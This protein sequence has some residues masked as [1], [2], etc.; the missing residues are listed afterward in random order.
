MKF[1]IVFCVLFIFWF[2]SQTYWYNQCENYENKLNELKEKHEELE[3]EYN[4]IE[5]NV[6]DNYSSWNITNSQFRAIV[7]REQE[8]IIDEMKDLE[9]EYEKAYSDYSDCIQEYEWTYTNYLNKSLEYYEKWDY[10]NA[11]KYL[12]KAYSINNSEETKTLLWTLYFEY[13]NIKFEEYDYNTAI[14]YYSLY[15]SIYPQNFA[16]TFNIWLTYYN[17]KDYEN[18]EKY[19]KK[20]IE[21]SNNSKEKEKAETFLKDIVATQESKVN[22]SH[23]YKQYRMQKMNIYEAWESINSYNE[24]TIAIIDDW[25]NINHPDLTNN[26]WINNKEIPGNWIDD[27]YNWFVDDFNWRNFVYDS[28]NILPLW[29]H[30]TMIAWIIWAEI[31]NNRWIAGIV[32]NVKLMSVWVCVWKDFSDNWESYCNEEHIKN[33][34]IYAIN[35][36]ADIINISLWW[37][38]FIYSDSYDDILEKAYKKWIVITIAAGNWDILSNNTNWVNTTVN[39]ISPVC[40]FWN[41]SSNIIWVG[42]F[43][44]NWYRASRSNYWNCIDFY[45]FGENII[46]TSIPNDNFWWNYDTWDWTS[47]STP[48]ITWI[49]WIWYN[50]YWKTNQQLIYDALLESLTENEVGN[51][52]INAKIYLYFLWLN[53]KTKTVFDSINKKFSKYSIKKKNDKLIYIL[54]ILE[55]YENKITNE[56]KLYILKYLKKLIYN[57]LYYK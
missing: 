14:K 18:S 7:I 57:E 41:N 24:V 37:S 2:F 10:L 40:N 15:L 34:I 19:I 28:N 17:N 12:E 31:N 42:A 39:K 56:E 44:E 27:D 46:S 23:S 11:I 13:W 9:Y 32:K 54:Q 20:A 50:K 25:I 6:K 48:M 21:Y 55:T 49:I 22:D 30:G 36:W 16:I 26:I 1:K 35:N 51:T 5:D 38:Q 47:F 29:N 52:M 8:D 53:I 45:W 4:N 43:D 3:D 33:G